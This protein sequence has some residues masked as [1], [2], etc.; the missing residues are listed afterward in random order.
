MRLNKPVY[1]G[2]RPVPTPF[3]KVATKNVSIV[4]TDI[5]TQ[6]FINGLLSAAIFFLPTKAITTGIALIAIRIGLAPSSCFNI[7]SLSISVMLTKT[8]NAITKT[9]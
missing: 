2:R 5:F 9:I 8:N 4:N 1:I 3:V 6:I 7:S